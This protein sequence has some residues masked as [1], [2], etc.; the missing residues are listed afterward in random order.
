MYD[1]LKNLVKSTLQLY[2]KQSVIGNCWNGIAYKNIDLLNKS[3]IVSKKKLILGC[4]TELA[5]AELVKKNITT[6]VEI[7]AFKTECLIFLITTTQKIFEP[8]PLGSTI[9]S[10]ASSLNPANL[11][12]P[13]LLALFRS[14]ISRLVYFKI[15]QPKLGD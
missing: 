6:S 3:N 12:H 2:I 4:A 7:E 14:L 9:F 5:I 11:N 15:L 13:S 10:D 8:L 1:D